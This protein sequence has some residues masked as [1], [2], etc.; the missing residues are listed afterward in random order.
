MFIVED[1]R[2]F[3]DPNM[4]VCD[5]FVEGERWWDFGKIMSLF[6][7]REIKAIMGIP[8]SLDDSNDSVMWH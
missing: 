4:N 6:S 8:L 2:D 3:I 7:L 1:S 5:L